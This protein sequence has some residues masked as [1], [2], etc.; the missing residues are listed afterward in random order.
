EE[1][2][3]RAA[4]EARAR[5]EAERRARETARP[6]KAVVVRK[7]KRRAAEP[8]HEHKPKKDPARPTQD[9]WGLYDP[10]KAGFG[11]LFAK[12][13]AIDEEPPEEEP[14]AAD[15]LAG[16]SES[17]RSPRPLSMWV[18]RADHDEPRDATST[19]GSP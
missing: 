13:D 14:S 8:V 2:S 19:T 10:D 17:T 6:K 18:W 12:L 4:A 11:A 16:S 7:A 15:L 9:E 3:R 1:T 5:Q